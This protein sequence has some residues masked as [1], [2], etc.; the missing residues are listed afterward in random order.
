MTTDQIADL[1]TSTL[2][3]VLALDAP[4]SLDATFEGDLRAD[5]LDLVETVELVEAEL[6]TAGR[7]A[8]I[9][10]ETLSALE[11]VGDAVRALETALGEAR[12]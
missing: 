4:P 5:S 3:R 8:T 12:A 9:P 6:R 1:V 2:Q 7:P 11:T 10:D